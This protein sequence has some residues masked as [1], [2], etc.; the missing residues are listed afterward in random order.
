[1]KK[2]SKFGKEFPAKWVICPECDGEGHHGNPA[3][4]GLSSAS[5]FC[6]EHPNF[7]QEYMDGVHDVPCKKCHCTGKTLDVDYEAISEQ[8]NEWLMEKEDDEL[9]NQYEREYEMMAMGEYY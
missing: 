7:M 3:Y 4:N 2:V 8:D 1:M 9:E 5:E 6:Q